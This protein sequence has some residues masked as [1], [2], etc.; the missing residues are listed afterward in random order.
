M[1]LLDPYERDA[2]V[3][4]QAGTLTRA[5]F[6]VTL[7][8]WNRFGTSLEREV[9]DGTVI[10]RVSVRSASGSKWKSL[11]K[12][13]ALYWWFLRK[14]LRADYD[15]LLVH[16]LYL[17]PVGWLLRLIRRKKTIFDAHEPYAEQ[18]V[19]ILPAVAPFQEWLRRLEAFF[20]RRADILMTVTPRMVTRYR[21]MGVGRILYLPNLPVCRALAVPPAAAPASDVLV[22]G[23]IGSITPRYS[24]V[25]PLI[26]L[27]KTL[28][29]RGVPVRLVIGGPI[30]SGWEPEFRRRI[31]DCG[32]YIDYLGVVPVTQVLNLVAR[33]HI[34]LSLR[35]GDTPKAEYGYSTKIFDAMAVGVP[36]ISTPVGEDP[37]LV[38]DTQCG[39]IVPCPVE[40]EALADRVVT[41][42]RDEA[43]R[44]RYGE[45]GLRA[46]RSQYTWEVY[47]PGFLA[48]FRTHQALGAD[49]GAPASS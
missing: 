39:E 21:E 11:L 9:R 4:K 2:R 32:D 33:F 30:M 48:E 29:A 25:E 28:R 26:E 23:R 35:D 46:I 37:Y 12:L 22:I 43:R 36:V 17:W 40:V 19:G 44:R 49:A 15:V 38:R 10:E 6:G 31:A 24:G 18:I 27:A 41:L 16:E 20:A 47:E 7:L 34:M 1:L 45:N 42:W 3:E 8:A 5:G 13:P 14:G